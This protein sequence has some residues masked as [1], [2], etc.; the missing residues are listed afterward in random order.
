MV[1]MSFSEGIKNI[2]AALIEARKE[3]LQSSFT[4]VEAKNP[5]WKSKFIPLQE[6]LRVSSQPLLKAGVLMMQS[7]G[8]LYKHGEQSYNF[9]SV[10]TIFFHAESGEWMSSTMTM[11]PESEQAQKVLSVITYMKRLSLQA[12]LGLASLSEDDDAEF[13]DYGVAK[14]EGY[15]DLVKPLLAA[16][17]KDGVGAVV[18]DVKNLTMN[19]KKYMMKDGSDPVKKMIDA[20]TEAKEADKR[21][22]KQVSK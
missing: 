11:K 16:F 18:D 2:T 22:G 21:K 6:I 20:V 3:I 19:I 1:E 4:L 15:D 9:V 12:L 14:P 10:Q 17:K 8:R 5:H 13:H 7:A